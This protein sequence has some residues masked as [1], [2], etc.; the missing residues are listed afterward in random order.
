MPGANPPFRAFGGAPTP[1]ESLHEAVLKKSVFY[2]RISTLS[3]CRGAETICPRFR[4]T[5]RAVNPQSS[6]QCRKPLNQ[7]GTAARIIRC[8]LGISVDKLVIDL[9]IAGHPICRSSIYRIESRQKYFT[10]VEMMAYVKILRIRAD[11]LFMEP[12]ELQQYLQT[13][14]RERHQEARLRRNLMRI[15]R[16]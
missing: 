14:L 6:M 13:H 8:W 2:N 3:D 10:D 7:T 4:P 1:V 11:L 16:F 5:V 9:E 12:K 15:P